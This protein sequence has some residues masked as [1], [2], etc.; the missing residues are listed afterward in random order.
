MISSIGDL[1]LQTG[2]SEIRKRIEEKKLKR[3]IL[4]YIEKEKQY[5][6]LY[7]IA[8][9]Y[10][11][12][13][14]L[15]YYKNEL[16]E[17]IVNCLLVAPSKRDTIRISIIRKARCFATN[18]EQS[19][20]KI[21]NIIN[22]TIGIINNYYISQIPNS[23]RLLLNQEMINTRRE[24]IVVKNDNLS[25]FK[26]NEFD[27][28]NVIKTRREITLN[29]PFFPWLR[30]SI[31]FRDA[32]L[33]ESDNLF[34]WP[35]FEGATSLNE[36]MS[37]RESYL[38]FLGFAGAG[39]STFFMY[40][41]AFSIINDRH[42][43]YL[44]AIDVK[45]DKSL[46]ENINVYPRYNG[47]THLLLIDGVDEAFHNDYEGYKHFIE[48]LRGYC[49]CRVWLAC[50]TDFFITYSGYSTSLAERNIIL[51]PWNDE[52]C[53]NFIDKYSEICKIEG[54]SK[55][56]DS[57]LAL[58]EE[59]YI[60]GTN[61]FQL[62]LLVYLVS[63]NDINPVSGIFNLYERFL[64]QWIKKEIKRGTCKNGAP[65]IMTSLREA[66][67]TLY[68]GDKWKFDNVANNNT[69]VS[70]LLIQED[71]D[72]M[73]NAIAFAFYHRSLASFIIAQYLVDSLN[74]CNHKVTMRILSS[75]RIKDD[76]TN[77]VGDR[78]RFL[79]L[80]EKER[81]KENIE[82]MYYKYPE[83]EENLCFHDHL[84]YFI[85]RI[86]ANVDQFLYKLVKR[87]P[88]NPIIRLSLAYGCVLSENADIRLYA[89]NYA[90]SITKG[91]LDAQTNRGWT[92]VYFGDIND[93][94]PYTYLDNEKRSWTKARTARISRFKKINPRLKDIRFWLFDIPLFHSFLKDRNWN[95]ISLSE[96]E[97]IKSLSITD[98]F[99]NSQEIDFLEEERT[100]LLNDYI[101]HL[102]LNNPN[103]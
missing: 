89:L 102:K 41:F 35:R 90:R 83:N 51:E 99:F 50:R 84:I 3:I 8:E 1:I 78:F 2:I 58:S 30:D 60:L 26:S 32:A 21:D 95:E 92:L 13:G 81:I 33:K 52:Q 56:I 100:S 36:I 12:E 47:N 17:D 101:N 28:K 49:N 18:S 7:S 63:N 37:L 25:I 98:Q 55:K 75:I 103:C 66:A 97:I 48:T 22:K 88:K 44:P 31:R 70:Y 11:Y 6:G 20:M 61:P 87:E 86:G 43:L 82:A 79:R 93:R 68:R 69:A 67:Q 39:K 57:L 65:V 54:L 96:Y 71:T 64:K 38:F 10:D 80:P 59:L 94:D 34:I 23:Y 85:T 5:N 24:P 53:H 76:V 40:L 9:E 16:I 4:S 46:L 72:I 14:L 62:S 15:E 19:R 45:N 74:E 91:K 73:G 42:V 77:F 27:L 29:Q